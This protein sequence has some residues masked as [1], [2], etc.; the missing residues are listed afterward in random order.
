VNYKLNSSVV[1][2]ITTVLTGVLKYEMFDRLQ[3][4]DNAKTVLAAETAQMELR[5]IFLFNIDYK[6]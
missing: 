5:N 4:L 6:I 1:F 2:D 3:A